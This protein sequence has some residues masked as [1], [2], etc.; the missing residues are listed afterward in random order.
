[1]SRENQWLGKFRAYVTDVDD[2]DKRGRIR[3]KCPKVLGDSKSAWCEVCAP[4]A[5]DNGGDFCL[6]KV[7]ESVWIEFE[8]G[9]VDKPIWV[10]GWW[11][12]NN[13]PITN[14]SQ[15]PSTRVIE[16]RGGKITMTQ[17]KIVITSGSSTITLDS[18]V[19]I[20]TSG[21]VTINGRTVKVD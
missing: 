12:T 17:G 3:V 7:G 11:S 13:S 9:D 8:N 21:S 15:A 10:G 14:Y 4:I 18:S 20:S 1:M 16:Y 6:P 2:P 19:R 5:Y